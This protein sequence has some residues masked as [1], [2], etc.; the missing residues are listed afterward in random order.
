VS[1]HATTL[2]LCEAPSTS[3]MAGLRQGHPE[4]APALAEPKVGG[5]LLNRQR[6]SLRG[7]TSS[8]DHPL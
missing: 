4:V 6:G 1:T 7:G 3:A 2:R 8:G 5:M